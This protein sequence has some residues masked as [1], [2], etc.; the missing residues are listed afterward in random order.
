M[1][2]ILTPCSLYRRHTQSLSHDGRWVHKCSFGF[3]NLFHTCYICSQDPGGAAFA[4]GGSA[5]H[6]SGGGAEETRQ[7]ALHLCSTASWWHQVPQTAQES[8]TKKTP[9][10]HAG[11]SEIQQNTSYP[12]LNKINNK[13]FTLLSIY[14]YISKFWLQF[15]VLWRYQIWISIDL[16]QK[17]TSVRNISDNNRS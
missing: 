6:H 8:V 5:D 17:G 14:I 7:R 2:L 9:K 12:S 16:H 4:W 13:P 3:L 15:S 11:M 10:K 1:K